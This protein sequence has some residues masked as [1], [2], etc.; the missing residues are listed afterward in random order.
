MKQLLFL[1]FVFAYVLTAKAQQTL[2]P[3][4][5]ISINADEYSRA[6]NDQLFEFSDGSKAFLIFSIDSMTVASSVNDTNYSIPCPQY[7]RVLYVV[8]SNYQFKTA[9]SIKQTS[10][11]QVGDT[12]FGTSTAFWGDSYDLNPLG[13]PVIA[14][15]LSNPTRSQ[16]YLVAYD[17]DLHLVRHQLINTNAFSYANI[18]AISNGTIYTTI[19]EKDSHPQGGQFATGR[20]Q[21]QAYDMNFNLLSSHTYY[22]KQGTYWNFD[23]LDH[24]QNADNG[25]FYG[26]FTSGSVGYDF[27]IGLN[28]TST[29]RP[30]D[31][32]ALGYLVKYD[33]N[34][35]ILWD[36]RITYE[37][38]AGIVGTNRIYDSPNG[39]SL[40]WVGTTGADI[41]YYQIGSTID[42]LPGD[43]SYAF[44]EQICTISKT[45]GQLQRHHSADLDHIY[46]EGSQMLR[47]GV[48]YK[49]SFTGLVTPEY[50][51]IFDNSFPIPDS[52]VALAIY[53]DPTTA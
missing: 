14:S 33:A 29:I 51:N 46:G 12:L 26:Y 48:S 23:L 21:V 53:D 19:R 39:D 5:L 52:T 50:L 20:Q 43:T 3:D 36:A 45:T 18:R 49:S 34:L 4:T 25:G 40:L 1:C 30:Y 9:I 8:D 31:Q 28:G 11:I 27:D 44:N 37:N 41:M 17:K 2:T 10:L 7:S 47:F 38:A 16:S 13:T 35:N 32:N 6:D 42:T 24:F 22:S 15:G